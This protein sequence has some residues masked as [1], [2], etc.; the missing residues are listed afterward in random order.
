MKT[1]KKIPKRSLFLATFCV[2]LL[3]QV[4]GI[5]A[6]PIDGYDYT[7]IKRLDYYELA[8]RGEVKGRQLTSGAMLPMEQIHLRGAA[9]DLDSAQP[10]PAVS[11]ALKGF[12][13]NQAA[14]YGV[15]LVDLSDPDQPLYAGFNDDYK[16]NVGSV[17]KILVAAAL[18][19]QL[20][21]RFPND[22]EARVN[23]LKTKP[24]TAD[25]FIERGNH[26]VRFWDVD[27]RKLTHRKLQIGDTAS[28]WEYLDWTLSVSS[29][30]AAAMVLREV[31]LM[32]H[33]GAAYPV[34]QAEESEFLANAST[35]A[36]RTLMLDS[37]GEVVES[38]GLN[39]DHLKQGS[40]FTRHGKNRTG[41]EASYGTPKELMKLLVRMEQ[42]QLV[43]EFSSQ[44]LKRMLY[45]T[46]RR[47]RYASHPALND[48]AVYFKSGS[49]YSCKPEAGFTC[50]KYK[51]NKRN[52]L[53]SVAIVESPTEPQEL[54]YMVVVMSNVLKVNSAVA[55]QTLALRI[56]RMI[57]ARHE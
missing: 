40:F 31:I 18:Y 2:F 1:L 42:G 16:A 29:N 44:D 33:F 51:G 14:R 6:Y 4:T 34:S 39:P 27:K 23:L 41:G 11:K 21:E 19:Q 9:I 43:D 7:G 22:I 54:R 17:G 20:A 3:A 36:L 52:Q 35:S 10:D 49:L 45:M 48:Y 13:G 56:H 50:G 55:H 46:E 28:V 38:N 57:E 37:L 12:L 30:S 8:Q 25:R 53:A 32:R 24:I 47:I 26:E 15:A 5:G